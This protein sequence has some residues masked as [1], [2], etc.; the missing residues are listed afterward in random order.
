MKVYWAFGATLA[1][2]AVL[3]VVFEA[4]VVSGAYTGA[5]IE[6][7]YGIALFTVRPGATLQGIAIDT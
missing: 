5:F 4:P 7:A 2:S 6:Y 1:V 3:L